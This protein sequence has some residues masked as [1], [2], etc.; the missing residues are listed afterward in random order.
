MKGFARIVRLIASFL[1]LVLAVPAPLQADQQE[2]KI[3]AQVQ[4]WLVNHGK[5]VD[6][7]PLYDILNPIADPLKAV[8]DPLY[9]AP[10]VFTLGRDPY[11]NVASVPGG[12]VYVSEKTFDFIQ[13]REEFAGALC[14]AVAHTVNHDY[15]RL[16]RKNTNA[17]LGSLALWL[18]ILGGGMIGAWSNPSVFGNTIKAAVNNDAAGVANA[19]GLGGAVAA[20]AA[21]GAITAAASLSAAEQAERGADVTGADLCAKAGINPWGMVW[22]LQNYRKAK[23]AGRMEMLSD[24]PAERVRNLQEHFA[25]NPDLFAKFD[26]ERAHATPLK[27]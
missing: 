3:G 8:A 4:K 5:I 11:P 22:L 26:P 15:V 12:R 24:T 14:H 9:D 7:S 20:G 10:F 25:S 17:Q 6:Q 21:A 23:L 27:T 13:Y 1:I 2:A 18:A 19:S 16:V